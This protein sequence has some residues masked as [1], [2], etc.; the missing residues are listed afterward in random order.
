MTDTELALAPISRLHGL[1]KNKTVSPVELVEETLDRIRD[2]D[3]RLHSYI[4]VTEEHALRQA[5]Q[6]EA[7]IRAGKIRGPL[8]GIPFGLKDIY[9]TAG[10][11]TTAGSPLL[12]QYV[13]GQDATAVRLLYDAG[14][15][16][17]GKHMTHEFAHGGPVKHGPWPNPDNPWRPGYF[18]GG[19]SSGSA[20]AVAAGLCHFALGSDTG[21]SI[22]I[23]AALCGTVGLKPTFGRVSRSGVI[24]N[25]L[26]L[27]H[28]GP[29]TWTVEDCAYVMQ[30]LAGHDPS[31]PYSSSEQVPDFS[32][33]M[34]R[35][36][37]GLRIGVV[38]H[39][40]TQD[41][42]IDSEQLAA[43]NQ[44][45]EVFEQLGARLEPVRLSTL[46]L[47]S[48]V[49]ITISA[50]ELFTFHAKNLRHR[51]HEFGPVFR[52]R[53]LA[54][55][56]IRAEDYIL[57]QKLKTELTTQLDTL[58]LK[59]DALLLPAAN[60]PAPL[61]EDVDPVGYF[62]KPSLNAPFNV[63]GHPAISICSGFNSMGLPLSLQIVGRGFDEATV[64][65]IAHAYESSTA[66]NKNRPRLERSRN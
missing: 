33:K 55:S 19:S 65:Q 26:S 32:E 13:P 41:T 46:Q 48:D 27:D 6:A 29:L 23:P 61:L 59:Y 24:P 22:R 39:F 3:S 5:R 17:V 53:A 21:G 58:L 20:V 51:P 62:D 2:L 56:F 25:A 54:G 16:L 4:T 10:I 57:A 1:I 12:H 7:E 47:Y 66:W 15:I 34:D 52:F 60:G 64:L 14:A 50:S 36:I 45:A 28:C 30:A 40:Y 43:F 31:D 9:E 18:T 63:T 38:E 42:Q 49:K 44:A 35:G 11:T 8:H 37:S